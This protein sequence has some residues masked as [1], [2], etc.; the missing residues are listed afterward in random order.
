LQSPQ[1]TFSTGENVYNVSFFSFQEADRHYVAKVK[2]RAIN[3][4]YYNLQFKV[5]DLL[6]R[7]S[8]ESP[9]VV[10][11]AISTQMKGTSRTIVFVGDG[12]WNSYWVKHEVQM[13]LKAGKPVYAIDLPYRNK[14]SNDPRFLVDNNIKIHSWSEANLQKLATQPV[15]PI[16]EKS[17]WDLFYE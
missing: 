5:R 2:G 16:R 4:R 9:I 14:F 8:T 3:P 11:R 6:R 10:K 1:F 15:T 12:T 13:S 7:W 17:I